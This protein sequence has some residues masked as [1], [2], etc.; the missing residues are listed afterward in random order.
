MILADRKIIFNFFMFFGFLKCQL[1]IKYAQL[2]CAL[3]PKTSALFCK[4][5]YFF[6]LIYNQIVQNELQ[7]FCFCIVYHVFCVNDGSGILLWSLRNR[8]YSAKPD[9]EFFTEGHA[10]DFIFS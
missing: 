4:Q 3:T 8:R 1:T 6:Q 5:H 9:P 2:Y 10:Q 7:G